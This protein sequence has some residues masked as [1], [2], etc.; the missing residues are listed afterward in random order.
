MAYLDVHDSCKVVL[1]QPG[2]ENYPAELDRYNYNQYAQGGTAVLTGASG[3]VMLQIPKFYYKYS[4]GSNTHNYDVSLERKPGYEPHPAFYRNG[5]WVDYRYVGIYQAAGWTGTWQ[6]GD[7]TNAWFSTSTGKLG[8]VS[9]YKPLSNFSRPNFRAA[10]A[11]VG[12]GWS[13]L[14][15]WTYS[16]L[17]MLYI[18]KHGNFNSQTMLGGGNTKFAGWNFAADVSATGKV[19]SI[20]SPGQSTAGGNSGD[21]V[22]FMGIEDIF[23]TIW[24]WVD[25][26]NINSGVN[27]VCSNSAN[28]ADDT[29]TNYT[30]FGTT[31][32][33]ATGWQETLQSNIGF[34]PATVGGTGSDVARITDYY[35]YSGGWV[36]PIV[37][38]GAGNGSD[39]GLFCLGADGAA[40]VVF[41]GIGSRLCF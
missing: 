40:S 20:T 19:T 6:Q 27:Y 5:A 2:N 25:G 15:F 37:G 34:L 9:G 4:F 23:G 36:A 21:Y 41:S 39:C 18:T 11:R 32:P 28:F 14:D 3:N 8:S 38:G 35:Y 29:T 24:Q 10:A 12:T 26:W 7:G 1:L 30:L 13:L 17:K 16:M 22:N 31:N 33:T